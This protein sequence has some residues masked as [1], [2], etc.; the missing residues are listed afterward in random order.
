MSE[1]GKKEVRADDEVVVAAERRRLEERVR[2]LE[3]LLGRKTM[4]VKILK[5]RA[6]RRGQRPTL[7]GRHELDVARSNI[8][9]RPRRWNVGGDCR[10]K[11][12]MWSSPAQSSPMRSDIV[13]DLLLAELTDKS[14]VLLPPTQ[15]R[16][17][18]GARYDSGMWQRSERFHC[19][20]V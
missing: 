13:E 15:I 5:R 1:G 11:P 12:A 2:E 7:D 17:G 6:S 10:S 3:G 20:R 19:A 14:K 16:L 9:E 8:I 18:R 4:E